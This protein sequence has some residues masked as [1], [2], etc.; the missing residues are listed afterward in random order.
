MP[1]NIGGRHHQTK[2]KKKIVT[3]KNKGT[4]R[5]KARQE[6]SNQTN[7]LLGHPTPS[8]ILLIIVKINKRGTQ[9]PKT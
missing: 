7:K 8:K 4:T 3:Q 2:K 1:A 5:N 9:R 6:K